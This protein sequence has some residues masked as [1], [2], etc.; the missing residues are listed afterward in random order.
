LKTSLIQIG[1]QRHGAPSLV[2]H[3]G[4][5]ASVSSITL[6]QLANNGAA[7]D[8]RENGFTPCLAI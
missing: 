7:G 4:R 5:F 1:K 6:K 8:I 3:F 2:R